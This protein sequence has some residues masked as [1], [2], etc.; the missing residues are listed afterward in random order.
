MST[1]LLV[2]IDDTIQGIVAVV[3]LLLYVGGF[4]IGLGAVVWTIMS[5]I[6]PTRLRMK[7][8]SMFLSL[9]WGGTL[10]VSLTTLYAING[11]GG[12]EAS[13]DDDEEGKAE[14]EGVAYLY[15][16]FAGITLSAIIFTHCFVPETKGMT[17]EQL[18]HPSASSQLK[19]TSNHGR[20]G[21][22]DDDRHSANFTS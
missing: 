17:P 19:N 16:I 9:T 15:Y 11:L 8:V 4:A 14:K 13:M 1:V 10:L 6:M 3:A 18:E 2:P 20:Q 22:E 5:E 12:V 21:T 7:A